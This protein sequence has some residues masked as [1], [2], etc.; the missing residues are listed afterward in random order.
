[1]S[2]FPPEQLISITL[3]V[4]AIYRITAPELIET[5]IPHYFI[6]IAIEEE[7]IYL[8]LCTTKEGT[9]KNYLIKRGYDLNSMINLQPNSDNRLTK[10]TYINC[11]YSHIVRK[12]DLINKSSNNKLS[13][14]G[15]LSETEYQQITKA[16]GYS[17]VN[18]IPKFLLV[19]P[20][21]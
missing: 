2:I 16:I 20:T 8:S 10:I 6:V 14:T 5:E 1:M 9:I 17:T 4:G 15:R 21:E 12:Q 11:N 7:L 3:K 18:D 13:F 19:Y